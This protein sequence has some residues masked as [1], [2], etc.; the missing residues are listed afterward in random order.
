MTDMSVVKLS[1]IIVDHRKIKMKDFDFTV[2]FTRLH[3]ISI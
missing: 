2:S 3:T 1:H